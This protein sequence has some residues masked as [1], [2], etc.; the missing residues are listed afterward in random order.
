MS[1]KEDVND[2]DEDD[3]EEHDDE[4]EDGEENHHQ[5]TRNL[6]TN[7]SSPVHA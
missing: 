1:K 2:I 6:L 3:D 4:D 5:S 7:V